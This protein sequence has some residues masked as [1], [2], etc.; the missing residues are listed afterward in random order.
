MED[1]DVA[2]RTMFRSY[3]ETQKNGAAKT[4]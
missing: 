4:I 1:A 3:I 2:I